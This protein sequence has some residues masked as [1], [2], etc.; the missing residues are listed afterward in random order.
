MNGTRSR[1]FTHLV[2]VPVLG[3]GGWGAEV[4]TALSEGSGWWRQLVGGG[5]FAL[6]TIGHGINAPCRLAIV[7]VTQP[8]APSLVTDVQ[9]NVTC[10]DGVLVYRDYAFVGGRSRFEKSCKLFS[11]VRRVRR[12]ACERALVVSSSKR[13]RKNSGHLPTL[14]AF[15]LLRLLLRNPKVSVHLRTTLETTATTT[16]AP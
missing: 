9:T 10:M 12:A 7:N 11:V 1:L 13:L 15:F 3:W 8:D 4:F 5:L 14:S 2:Q 16:T 6:V